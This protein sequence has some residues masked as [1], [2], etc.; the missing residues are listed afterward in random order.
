[1]V[2]D[3]RVGVLPELSDTCAYDVTEVLQPINRLVVEIQHDP[4]ASSRPA[5]LYGL[6]TLEITGGKG[7]D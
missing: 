1:M 2:N 3:H 7:E 5:G 6:V 4:T